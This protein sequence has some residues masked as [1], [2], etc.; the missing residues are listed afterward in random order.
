MALYGLLVAVVDRATA[1]FVETLA[2]VAPTADPGLV[3]TA[4]AVA[5]WVALAGVVATEVAR[6]YGATS[7]QLTGREEV[8]SY[9]DGRRPDR[10]GW[11]LAAGATLGGAGAVAV[12]TDAFVATLDGVLSAGSR[13]AETGEVGGISAATVALGATFLAGYVALAWGLDQL[14]VGLARELQ[15][16]RAVE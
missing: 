14:V 13:L 5:L 8:V 6:Q 2:S 12:T 4:M 10:R 1:A 15:Y 9:L 16:R 7:P 11:A 3:T